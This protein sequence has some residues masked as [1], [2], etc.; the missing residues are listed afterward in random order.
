MIYV[1]KNPTSVSTGYWFLA[2]LSPRLIVRSTQISRV[3]STF[4]SSEKRLQLRDIRFS[5]AIS[6]GKCCGQCEVRRE[7]H[8]DT[9]THL[10]QTTNI[11]LNRRPKKNCIFS[12]VSKEF[13]VFRHGFNM[14]QQST[15]HNFLLF[16]PVEP[17]KVECW[18]FLSIAIAASH[19]GVL[20]G[21]FRDPAASRQGSDKN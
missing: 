9:L 12:L 7:M 1:W 13:T 21:W 17:S 19:G 8:G 16:F 10:F 4:T 5:M 2:T 11:P 18:E 15:P 14:F 6:M 20:P 3:N